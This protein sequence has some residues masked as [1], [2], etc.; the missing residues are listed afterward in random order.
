MGGPGSGGR[1]RKPVEVH[2]RHGTYRKDRHGPVPAHVRQKAQRGLCYRELLPVPCYLKPVAAAVYEV[3][4]R[5]LERRSPL[6]PSMHEVALFSTLW[7]ETLDASVWGKDDDGATYYGD[8][9]QG[10]WD[11]LI[12]RWGVEAREFNEGFV[13]DAVEAYTAAWRELGEEV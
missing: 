10:R 3:M 12:A 6:R 7:T 9:L 4:A 2:L 8:L 13:D 5:F 11:E 1:N